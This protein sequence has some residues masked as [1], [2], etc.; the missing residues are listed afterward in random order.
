M[1]EVGLHEAAGGLGGLIV[2]DER[3]V[4]LVS[5]GELVEVLSRLIHEESG[6]I[7]RGQDC[8]WGMV[9]GL[10]G[11]TVRLTKSSQTSKKSHHT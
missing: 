11:N 7:E 4:F 10:V 6:G 8:V 2:V 5:G 9:D 1:E 3:L